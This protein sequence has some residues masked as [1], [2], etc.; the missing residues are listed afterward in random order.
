MRA[1]LDLLESCMVNKFGGYAREQGE[2]KY[3]GT[4]TARGISKGTPRKNAKLL[5]GKPLVANLIEHAPRPR[6]VTCITVPMD[7]I[8]GTSAKQEK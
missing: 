8:I 3:P 6:H 5:G 1:W 2:T 7:D 4:I